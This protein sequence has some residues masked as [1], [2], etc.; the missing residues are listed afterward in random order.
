MK[1]KQFFKNSM[2]T[3]SK[4]LKLVQRKPGCVKLPN[5]FYNAVFLSCGQLGRLFCIGGPVLTAQS[6]GH[7]N[8]KVAV[9]FPLRSNKDFIHWG[10]P[11]FPSIVMLSTERCYLFMIHCLFA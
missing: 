6:N 2:A 1:S 11:Y 5:V 10:L 8:E 3:V 9:F 7:F 4:Q